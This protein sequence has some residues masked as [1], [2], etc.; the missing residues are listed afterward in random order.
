[1]DEEIQM[2]L[3]TE[4]ALIYQSPWSKREQEVNRMITVLKGAMGTR[5]VASFAVVLCLLSPFARYLVSL[6]VIHVKKAGV[7]LKA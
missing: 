5:V 2:L 6:G 7:V 4:T 3:A 1:M